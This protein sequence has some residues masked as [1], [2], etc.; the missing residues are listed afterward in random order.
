MSKASSDLFDIFREFMVDAPHQ[1]L[2][3]GQAK[4]TGLIPN[5]RRAERSD[6][7]DQ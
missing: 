5:R 3:I 6:D 7:T 2:K 4:T 1:A